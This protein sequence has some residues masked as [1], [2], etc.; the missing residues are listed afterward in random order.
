MYI[1]GWTQCSA[2]ARIFS[3]LTMICS[4][5]DINNRTKGFNFAGLYDVNVYLNRTCERGSEIFFE[6]T[7]MLTLGACKRITGLGNGIWKDWTAYPISD[8]YNRIAVWKV[9]LLQL[10]SQ[11]P[12]PPLGPSVEMA[13]MLHLLGDPIHSVSSL[14][15]SFSECQKRSKQ[16]KGLCIATKMN[17][18]D[19]DYQKTWKGLAIVMVSYDE[20]GISEKVNDFCST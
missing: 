3:K 17:E 8:I 9:P 5:A 15:L 20:C 19:P 13:V 4:V 11:F 18:D 6:G 1:L 16:A 7:H 2:V 10:L 12:R 14:L